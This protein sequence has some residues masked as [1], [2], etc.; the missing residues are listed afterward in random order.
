MSQL[1]R[2]PA[3]GALAAIDP[4]RSK[5]GLVRSDPDRQRIEVAL[6]LSPEDAK[7]ELDTWLQERLLVA[8]LLG[9]GTGSRAWLEQLAPLA[10][11]LLIE[12]RGST[13][14]ARS[15]Y[16]QL[17]PAR[18]WRRLLP[19]GLRQPP[20]PWDDVVAQLLVEQA[21]GHQLEREAGG[22]RLGALG[23]G[24]RAWT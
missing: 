13:L 10:P 18:G 15:R 22:D 6:I 5:C 2:L 14:A 9:N 19:M 8:I 24:A 11:V 4:G 7:R 23:P 3:H 21:L 20:R 12:E 1:S 17:F 16:W